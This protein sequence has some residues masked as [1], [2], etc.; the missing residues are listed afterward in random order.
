MF[1]S[2]L[3]TNKVSAAMDNEYIQSLSMADSFKICKVCNMASLAKFG[4]FGEF[5]K[6]SKYKMLK[7]WKI[8]GLAKICQTVWQDSPDLLT[9]ANG[10]F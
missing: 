3:S 1:L 6:I 9:F 7:S 10:H 2:Q 5:S 8:L 4:K